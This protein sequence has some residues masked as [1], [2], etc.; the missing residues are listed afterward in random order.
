MFANPGQEDVN[1]NG[2]GDA[3]D[4]AWGDVAPRVAPNGA[5]DIGDVVEELRYSVGLDTPSVPQLHEADVAPATIV[6]GPPEVATPRL[7]QPP[8]VDITDVV[9]LLRASVGL[10][11]FTAPR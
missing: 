10:T 4:F 11:R 5:I 1:G 6:P 2:I 9:L 3:C 7:V 8:A